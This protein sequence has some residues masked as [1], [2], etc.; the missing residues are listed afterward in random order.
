MKI[1]QIKQ[2]FPDFRGKK[3]IAA[4]ILIL[5]VILFSV[6]MMTSTSVGNDGSDESYSVSVAVERASALPVSPV[7]TYKATLEPKEYGLV[8]TKIAG[9]VSS[10]F[11][12]NGDAVEQGQALIQIDTQDI[13]N[14]LASAANQL[15]IA[16]FSEQ[17]AKAALSSAQ[18][19]FDRAQALFQEGAV[20]QSSLDAATTSLQ[21]TNADYSLAQA[22]INTAKISM[23]FLKDQ[24]ANATICA[25]ISGIIDSK[26]VSVGQYLTTQGS[27]VVL[28]K[29]NDTSVLNAVIQVEQDRLSL[30]QVGQKSTVTLDGS[31]KT[32]EGMVTSID[33][34]ADPASRSFKCKI[35]LNQ[36]DP[37]L[38]PGIFT[39]VSFSGLAA[40]MAIT[41]P[42]DAVIENGGKYYLYL[43]EN[44]KAVRRE[45]QIGELLNQTISI[46]SGIQEGD[47][48]IISNVSMLQ[49]GDSIKVQDKEVQ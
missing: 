18:L 23:Q 27:N 48:V 15:K 26:N 1:K 16:S 10:I 25:P 35:A 14:Q 43:A 45:V 3:S 38:M 47:S 33:P 44:N 2:S 29:I 6:R 21:T 11:F 42:M 4:G 46:Q 37:E 31:D 30:I 39:T 34:S 32:F 20:S 36:K 41:V 17:K 49:D 28:A 5:L 40:K 24:M 9:K 19:A 8:T 13:E 22:N 7:Y 12:E